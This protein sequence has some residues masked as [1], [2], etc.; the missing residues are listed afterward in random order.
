MKASRLIAVLVVVA[1]VATV[2]FAGS[3]R[4]SAP[5]GRRL[6]RGLDTVL[7]ADPGA[8]PDAGARLQRAT[9]ARPC[10]V[11]RPD[12]GLADLSVGRGRVRDA[13]RAGRL[14]APG[15]RHDRAGRPAGP[16]PTDQDARIGSMVVD[17]G[18]P[19]ALGSRLRVRR[20][21]GDALSEHYDIVGMDPR[22]VGESVPID[23]LSD[24]DMDAYLAGDPDP[25]TPAG[26]GRVPGQRTRGSPPAARPTPASS[27]LTSPRSRRRATWTCCGRPSARRS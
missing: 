12:A 17:P 14:P 16:R 1:L 10:V 18:G 27:P 22:G 6:D 7:G 9:D 23:C 21:W 3:P 19:G 25:D 26:G 24:K 13:D 20:S 11:L 15:R 8:H 4:A 2:V 5:T